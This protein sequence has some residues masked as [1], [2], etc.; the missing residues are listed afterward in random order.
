MAKYIVTYTGANG[1]KAYAAGLDSE[2]N[3]QHSFAIEESVPYDWQVGA[4]NAV[5]HRSNDYS[6]FLHDSQDIY[7]I[8]GAKMK[9]DYEKIA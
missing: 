6:F 5:S 3:F 2:G 1:V 7:V 8:D 4:M 9:L